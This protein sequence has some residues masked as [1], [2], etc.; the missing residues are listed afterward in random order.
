MFRE[1]RSFQ[2]HRSSCR[3]FFWITFL[4]H[5]F[6]SPFGFEPPNFGTVFQPRL[7]I[8][9]IIGA[10]FAISKS[11]WH[12]W[13]P[14]AIRFSSDKKFWDKTEP[15]KKER[16]KV[17]LLNWYNSLYMTV[18]SYTGKYLEGICKYSKHFLM[19][20]TLFKLTNH[21]KKLH[22]WLF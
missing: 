12:F 4:D 9:G 18:T 19:P 20:M 8:I 10:R 15:K 2:G 1:I 7:D 6:F 11:K 22:Q 21:T 16:I 14:R 17:Y 5:Q 13:L 3:R